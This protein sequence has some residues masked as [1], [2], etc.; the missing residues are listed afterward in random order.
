MTRHCGTE[1]INNLILTRRRKSIYSPN[2]IKLACNIS[3][4]NYKYPHFPPMSAGGTRGTMRGAR[5]VH[6]TWHPRDPH[7]PATKEPIPLIFILQLSSHSKLVSSATDATPRVNSVQISSG[8]PSLG[9]LQSKY[10]SQIA[11]LFNCFECCS[12][13]AVLFDPLCIKYYSTLVS[14]FSF[15]GNCIFMS[16]FLNAIISLTC[17]QIRL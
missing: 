1:S 2:V 5:R 17:F 15:K 12:K 16:R 9:H 13:R 7:V 6:A 14:Y 3:C 4:S 10:R 8:T 11:L